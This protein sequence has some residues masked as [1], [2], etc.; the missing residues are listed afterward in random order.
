MPWPT[1]SAARSVRRRLLAAQQCRQPG[2]H[3][4]QRWPEPVDLRAHLERPGA[5]GQQP[6]GRAVEQPPAVQGDSVDHPDRHLD[7][8]RGQRRPQRRQLEDRDGHPERTHRVR[9]GRP[10]V[11]GQPVREGDAAPVHQLVDQSGGHDLPAQRVCGDR[12]RKARGQP[13]RELG[14][15]QLGE[16]GQVRHV[17]A[18]Q[19]GLQV[20]LG[21]GQQHGQL[22]RAQPDPGRGALGDLVAPTAGPRG[23]GRSRSGRPD[24]RSSRRAWPAVR[25]L[26]RGPRRARHSVPGCR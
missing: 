19:R 18:Q 10:D 23:S 11:G 1:R 21:V 4:A 7:R 25:W 26:G 6:A 14:A 20:Q 9:R 15:Q 16:L 3:R 12:R 2:Q 8:Q 22:R 24:R 13:G 5:V 17:G